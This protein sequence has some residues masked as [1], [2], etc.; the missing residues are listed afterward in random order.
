MDEGAGRRFG[1]QG[2][3]SVCS[4]SGGEGPDCLCSRASLGN[5]NVWVHGVQEDPRSQRRRA[6]KESAG[7]IGK[8]R[9]GPDGGVAG[10]RAAV[11]VVVLELWRAACNGNP[12]LGGEPLHMAELPSG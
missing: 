7:G 2:G 11:Q 12:G 8:H 10:G 3:P 6:T 9:R 1:A 5:W 4:G